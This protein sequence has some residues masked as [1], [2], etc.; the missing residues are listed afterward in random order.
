MAPFLRS[1]FSFLLLATSCSCVSR[2]TP[3][4]AGT[5]ATV[6]PSVFVQLD[7][8]LFVPASGGLL[9]A[10]DI[11]VPCGSGTPIAYI[12]GGIL[13]SFDPDASR[14]HVLQ[15]AP[16][17]TAL[18]SVPYDGGMLF[19]TWENSR[20]HLMARRSDGQTREI[21]LPFEPAQILALDVSPSGARILVESGPYDQGVGR[22]RLLEGPGMRV[23]MEAS[24]V[25]P[26]FIS[27]RYWLCQTADYSVDMYD[28]RSCA[29]LFSLP[30]VHDP[31][32]SS[33]REY[34][35][36]FGSEAPAGGRLYEIGLAPPT[37]REVGRIPRYGTVTFSEVA[38]SLDDRAVAIAGSTLSVG[39]DQTVY[40]LIYSIVRGRWVGVYRQARGLNPVAVERVFWME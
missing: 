12:A 28:A 11:R 10:S 8:Q 13:W 33:S 25:H 17:V 31:V 3:V 34:L 32:L 36:C 4:P 5:Q 40:L 22:V 6:E 9:P 24:G 38:W 29:L 15:S 21:P 20:G 23:E 27:D 37:A 30:H 1:T 35:Y 14:Y 39:K 19:A 18:A 26:A 2:R 16:R 7:S